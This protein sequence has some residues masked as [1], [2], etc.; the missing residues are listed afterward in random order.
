MQKPDD[1]QKPSKTTRE[2]LVCDHTLHLADK[3]GQRQG[4]WIDEPVGNRVR[5]ICRVCG[6]F[7][8]YRQE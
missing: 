1:F 7:Y 8:G 5:V 4:T 6:R 2:D 3:A